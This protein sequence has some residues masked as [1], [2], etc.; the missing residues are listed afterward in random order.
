M[1]EDADRHIVAPIDAVP[2][3]PAP[4]FGAVPPMPR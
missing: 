2:L 4:L 1:I 3:A